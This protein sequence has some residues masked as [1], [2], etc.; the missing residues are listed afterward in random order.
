M[1]H[2]LIANKEFTQT[3]RD[4]RFWVAGSVVLLLLLVATWTGFQNYESL[5]RSRQK[6]NDAA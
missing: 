6:A 4:R 3:L 2:Q 1:N 5:A